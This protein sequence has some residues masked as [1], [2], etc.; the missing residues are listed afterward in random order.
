VARGR[1]G[2]GLRLTAREGRFEDESWRVRKDGTRFWAN[3]ITTALRDDQGK[4]RGY[5]E[6]IR[7][8]TSRKL[9]EKQILEISDREQ[10]RIG[11]DLHDDLCQR[12]AGIEMMSQSLEQNLG[13]KSRQ[14]TAAAIEITKLI[15]QA[16]S[17]THDL[18]R[19]LSPVTLESDGLASALQELAADTE[20]L[21]NISC[22][23]RFDS[24]VGIP[25]NAVATHLYRIAQEALSNATKHGQ[26]KRVVISLTKVQD[27][28]VL[29]IQDD[30]VGLPKI[31]RASKGM[32]L[33]IMQYRAG[34]I[35]GTLTVERGPEGGTTVTCALQISNDNPSKGNHESDQTPDL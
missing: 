2:Q 25:Y 5:A 7:D 15:R 19:G 27:R 3:V 9:L 17:R 6:V 20:K 16:I 13:A 4:L 12:L 11:Q 32:G 18:A 35:G 14:E 33:R 28:V 30:G 23:F 21:F 24:S 1:P 22:Q 26:A 8:I 34:M 29:A 31:Q 10:R